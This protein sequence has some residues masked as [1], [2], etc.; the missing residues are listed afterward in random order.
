MK[1]LNKKSVKGRGLRKAA[2][3]IYFMFTMIFISTMLARGKPKKA[4]S[5]LEFKAFC[6][7]S[8]DNFFELLKQGSES[9]GSFLV[10]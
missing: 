9:K 7:G 6:W 3:F 10:Y 1:F 2:I 8:G 5:P 4:A